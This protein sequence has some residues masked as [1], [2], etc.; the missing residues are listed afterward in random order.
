MLPNVGTPG[1]VP[2][3]GLASPESGTVAPPV[4]RRLRGRT[5][6]TILVMAMMLLGQGERSH[7]DPRFRS[8]SAT[9]NTYWEAMRSGDNDVAQDC[10][11]ADFGY[12]PRPGA[13]WFMPPSDAIWLGGVHVLPVGNGHVLVRYEVHY[14]TAGAGE[15]RMFE[16]GTELLCARGEWRIAQGIGQASM[17]EWKGEPGPVDI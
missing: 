7:V 2:G 1:G 16:T 5:L 3:V 13:L 17:P 8:P 12:Q 14:R 4:H 9:L 11:A 15:E 6:A 10:F